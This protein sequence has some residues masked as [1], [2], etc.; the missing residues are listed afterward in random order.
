VNRQLTSDQKSRIQERSAKHARA[1]HD[2]HVTALEQAVLVKKAGWNGSP[3]ST[4]RIYAELWPLIMKEDW[5]FASP[6]AFSGSHNNQLWDHNKPYSYLGGQGAGGMGYGAP[7]SV[8]AALAAK[9]RNRFVVNVQTDGDLNYAPGVLWTAAHHKLPMLTVMHNNR[10]WHQEY[11][12]VEYMAGVRGRGADRAEIGSTLRDP[13]IDYAKM[14]ATYGMAGE[15][16]IH[17]PAK[18]SAALQRGVA[19]VKRS[20]DPVLGHDERPAGKHR[21]GKRCQWEGAV[22]HLR[23]LRFP[24]LQR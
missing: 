19:S 6:S 1:N 2:A 3:I 17:D 23:L 22:L 14:A 13:F 4:A 16:P 10:A 20:P 5:C 9:A 24:R 18:L 11:M 15:G 8:G 12:F 21:T 7:A